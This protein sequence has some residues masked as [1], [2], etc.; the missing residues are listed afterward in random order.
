MSAPHETL[1]SPDDRGRFTLRRFLP[2]PTPERWKLFIE[3]DGRR[4]ILE[5]VP[6]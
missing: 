3:D 6:E 1:I 2:R 4:M 5:A